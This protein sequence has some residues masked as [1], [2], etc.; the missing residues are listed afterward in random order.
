MWPFNRYVYIILFYAKDDSAPGFIGA[1]SNLRKA[2]RRINDWVPKF[3]IR[4]CIR[5]I[6]YIDEGDLG[7]R[8][9]IIQE[10]IH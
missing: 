7:I 4:R 3:K 6:W 9:S 8:Y 2:L 5:G 1:Y 10:K